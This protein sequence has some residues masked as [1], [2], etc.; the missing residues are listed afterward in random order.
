M[1]ASF[2]LGQIMIHLQDTLIIMLPVLVRCCTEGRTVF[3]SLL[4]FTSTPMVQPHQ[5][6]VPCSLRPLSMV[7]LLIPIPILEEVSPQ[8]LGPQEGPTMASTRQAQTLPS[9]NRTVTR[10]SQTQISIRNR[11]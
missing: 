1:V 9:S 11:R 8:K 5:V 4:V 3:Q 7:C 2:L 6:L 10:T